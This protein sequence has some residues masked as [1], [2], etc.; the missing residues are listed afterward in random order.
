M[1]LPSMIDTPQFWKDIVNVIVVLTATR[2]S[3]MTNF[4]LWVSLGLVLEDVHV[5]GFSMYWKNCKF[6]Y[7]GIWIHAQTILSLRGWPLFVCLFFFPPDEHIRQLVVL[8]RIL[9]PLQPVF[10]KLHYLEDHVVPFIRKWRAG[11]GLL[12]EHGGE[13]VHGQFNNLSRRYAAIPD[14]VPGLEQ[15][16]KLHWLRTRLPRRMHPSLHHAGNLDLI[17]FSFM[18]WRKQIST[19]IFQ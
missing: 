8:Y 4:L 10:P 15:M 16:L 9:S 14:A 6:V 13:S 5:F 19:Q 1:Q 2:P 11:P 7:E 12:G 17:L 3:L 18:F